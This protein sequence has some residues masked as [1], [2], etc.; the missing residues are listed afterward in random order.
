MGTSDSEAE[1]ERLEEIDNML[2]EH[3]PEFQR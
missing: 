3:D 2:R 1:E